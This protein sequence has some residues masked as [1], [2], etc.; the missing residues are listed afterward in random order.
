MNKSRSHDKLAAVR[1]GP[2]AAVPDDIWEALQVPLPPDA[3]EVVAHV[4]LFDP[5]TSD[6]IYIIGITRSRIVACIEP[7]R[8][9]FLSL[10]EPAQLLRPSWAYHVDTSFRPMPEPALLR[11]LGLDDD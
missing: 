3:S 11:L 6:E 4:R 8:H 10:Y 5:A 2:L 1:H 9:R 7:H